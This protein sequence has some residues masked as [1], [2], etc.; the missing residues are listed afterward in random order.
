MLGAREKKCEKE[1]TYISQ[2]DTAVVRHSFAH[3]SEL[4]N[5]LEKEL[6]VLNVIHRCINMS[7]YD[8]FRYVIA[9]LK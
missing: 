3:L 6:L 2:H 5:R 7:I 8:M 9:A 4:Y 1:R